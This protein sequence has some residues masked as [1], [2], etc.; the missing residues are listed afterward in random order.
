MTTPVKK[1]QKA[2]QDNKRKPTA[3][4]LH[5]QTQKAPPP[6][7]PTNA[8]E[9]SSTADGPVNTRTGYST[10]DSPGEGETNA[11]TAQA[12]NTYSGD[13]DKEMPQEVPQPLPPKETP[14]EDNPKM[15]L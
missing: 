1:S 2:L 3:Q 7:N 8:A 5:Q 6:V 9:P 4:E 11:G 15:V 12:I 14:V 13:G 10:P